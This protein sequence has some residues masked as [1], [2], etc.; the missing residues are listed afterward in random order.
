MT[1]G[2]EIL[3]AVGICAAGA[4]I[5]GYCLRGVIVDE[6]RIRTD[7]VAS[8]MV[9]VG[10]DGPGR[11]SVDIHLS[12]WETMNRLGIYRWVSACEGETP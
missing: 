8:V 11:C 5:F 2:P 1:R 4:G 3:L 9:H 6:D 10:K 7:A 12:T